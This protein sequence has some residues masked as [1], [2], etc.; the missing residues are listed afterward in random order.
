MTK[1]KKE[2]LKQN[3]IEAP[4]IK[5]RRLES[6]SIIQRT[7]Q[8]ALEKYSDKNLDREFEKIQLIS[9]EV[10]SIP[11]LEKFISKVKSE[12]ESIFQL[13]FYKEIYRLNRWDLDP[14]EYHKPPIVGKWTNQL[15]YGRFPKEVL[16]QLQILNP[17]V[18]GMYRASKHFQWL[19]KEGQEMVSGF[20]TDAIKCMKKFNDWY[21]FRKEYHAQYGVGY[22]LDAFKESPQK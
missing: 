12:Y 20:I 16:P 11:S 7:D 8:K 22:Q 18:N 1:V 10:V 14:K 6:L 19:N 9:G 5:D 17:Y 4:K 3:K 13:D 2:D 21:E 15:I